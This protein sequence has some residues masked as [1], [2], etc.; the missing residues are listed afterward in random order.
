M[1][2]KKLPEREKIKFT[3]TTNCLLID[4]DFIRFVNEY[5]MQVVL[6][7]DGRKSVHD[8]V[9]HTAGGEGTYDKILP[10]MLKFSESRDHDNY[11]VRGTYTRRNM[12]FSRDVL[13]LFD[14]GFKHVSLEP[15]V[16]PPD[17]F[18]FTE[19]D[20]LPLQEYEKVA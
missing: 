9:R 5:D 4:D 10:K 16:A 11:Y 3:I 18:G 13:H 7:L 14:L 15:V 2:Q 12:D 8:D 20:I 19:E 17:Q 1:G 6:S